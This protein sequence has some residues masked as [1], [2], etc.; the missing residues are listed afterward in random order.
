MLGVEDIVSINS[1]PVF[2]VKVSLRH[3]NFKVKLGG[4]VSLRTVALQLSSSQVPFRNMKSK[5]YVVIKSSTR[6]DLFLSERMFKSANL[7]ILL[8]VPTAILVCRIKGTSLD[9]FAVRLLKA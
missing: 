2:S 7:T 4:H 6:S 3:F 5:L 8:F 9:G 1:T